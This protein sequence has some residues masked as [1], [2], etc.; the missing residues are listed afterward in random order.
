MEHSLLLTHNNAK[1]CDTVAIFLV[2]WAFLPSGSDKN[3]L[4]LDHTTYNFTDKASSRLIDTS[5]SGT[6][7]GPFSTTKHYGWAVTTPQQG[8]LT[9]KPRPQHRILTLPLYFSV[10][11]F[12]FKAGFLKVL[13][14]SEFTTPPHQK[15]ACTAWVFLVVRNQKVQRWM[16]R[17]VPKFN[18]NPLPC[19]EATNGNGSMIRLYVL[20]RRLYFQNAFM[21]MCETS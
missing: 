15:S 16:K 12:Q 4:S 20:I 14:K 8:G 17:S 19:S 7:R 9:F 3:N 5:R 10:F 18:I 21:H 13:L 1:Q 2:K 11:Y 6:A